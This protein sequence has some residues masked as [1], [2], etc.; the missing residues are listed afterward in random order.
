MDMTS[1]IYFTYLSYF[2]FTLGKLSSKLKL[3]SIVLYNKW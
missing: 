1:C 3:S 2:G